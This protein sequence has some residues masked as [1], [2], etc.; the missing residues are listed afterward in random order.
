MVEVV[1]GIVKIKVVVFIKNVELQQI[2]SQVCKDEVVLVKDQF[3]FGWSSVIKI[4]E[5][6]VLQF[7]V[8]LKEVDIVLSYF[9]FSFYYKV[10]GLFVVI[11]YVFVVGSRKF[12]C[13][14]RKVSFVCFIVLE[15]IIDIEVIVVAYGDMLIVRKG[16]CIVSIGFQDICLLIV[17]VGNYLD[18]IVY[19][20]SYSWVQ[21][22]W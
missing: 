10:V 21:I 16:I 22:E 12:I 14:G 15:S 11:V 7:L 6:I 9:C 13:Q 17:V 18:I 4:I 3:F 8:Q 20:I 5:I 2:G 1:E 19:Y